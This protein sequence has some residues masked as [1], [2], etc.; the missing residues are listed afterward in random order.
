[1]H[2]VFSY[3]ILADRFNKQPQKATLSANF[4]MGNYGMY[5][6]LLPS[7]EK[8]SFDGYL[9]SLSEEELKQADFIEGYP[10]LY[11]RKKFEVISNG[12]SYMAWVYFV[13][14]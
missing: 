14:N 11:T 9:L 12:K 8:N 7:T 5:K 3:G 6:A 2:Y 1:M 4:S 10:D 13:E